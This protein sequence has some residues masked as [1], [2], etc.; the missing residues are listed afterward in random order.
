MGACSINDQINLEDF[1][2]LGVTLADVHA[3]YLETGDIGSPEFIRYKLDKLNADY[4]PESILKEDNAEKEYSYT[5]KTVNRWLTKLSKALGVSYEIITEQ[6]A[7]DIH[8]AKGKTYNN[9]PAFFN[10]GIAY[11]ISGRLTP[12]SVIHEFSHPFV[13]M[14]MTEN[15]ELFNT[16]YD[17]LIATEYCYYIF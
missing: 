10:K 16:L 17:R 7:R 14:L 2:K 5:E 11:F 15:P 8:N 12:Q 1:Q 4:I 9:E 13:K 3:H 6:E